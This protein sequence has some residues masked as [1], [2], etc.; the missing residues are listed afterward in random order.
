ME[1]FAIAIGY[2]VMFT[3]SIL[4]IGYA[5]YATLGMMMRAM[6]NRMVD[7][8]KHIQ[9]LYVMDYISKHGVK[10][11]KETAMKEGWTKME[12]DEAK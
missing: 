2:I 1:I 8:Y 12:K 11:T 7:T 3:V 5:L 9:L 10:K 4:F 6:A